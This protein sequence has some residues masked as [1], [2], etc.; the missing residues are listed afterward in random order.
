VKRIIKVR[1]VEKC[2]K[3]F[4]NSDMGFIALALEEKDKNCRNQQEEMKR[5][6]VHNAWKSRTLEEE[7]YTLLA[8]LK[9]EDTLKVKL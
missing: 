6:W 8:R 3:N 1:V 2:L 7:C 9:K 4:S 5:K